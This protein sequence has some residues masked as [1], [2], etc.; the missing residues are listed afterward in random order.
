[1]I[2]T[3]RVLAARDTTTRVTMRPGGPSYS[4]WR[5]PLAQCTNLAEHGHGHESTEYNADILSAESLLVLATSPAA[6]QGRSE[7]LVPFKLQVGG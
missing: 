7:L 6:A 1:M 2:G 4:D 3:D 5:Q